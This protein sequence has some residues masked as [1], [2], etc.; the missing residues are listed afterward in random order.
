MHNSLI[1]NLNILLTF[2]TLIVSIVYCIKI[3]LSHTFKKWELLILSLSS[4]LVFI[5]SIDIFNFVPIALLIIPFFFYLFK[6]NIQYLV[7]KF[8][9]LVLYLIILAQSSKII[10]SLFLAAIKKI[11]YNYSIFLQNILFLSLLFLITKRINIILNSVVKNIIP[12]EKYKYILYFCALCTLTTYYIFLMYSIFKGSSYI[13]LLSVIT[14]LIFI[15]L[16]TYITVSVL[17]NIKLETNNKIESAKLEQQ[18]KYI[19][20]LEKNNNE[21]KKFKHDF[22]NIILGLDGYINNDDFDKEKL[23]K[24]FNSTIMNYNNNIEL[25]DI[26]IAKLNSIKVSSL[27]SLITNKVL[28]AQNNNIDVDINIQG[29]IHDFYTDEMQL[30]RILG[31]LLDNAIEASLELTHDKKIEMNIIQIDKTTDIQ[32]SNTFNNTGTPITDFNKE[33]FSTKGTN[34]GLGLSSAH[35]IANKLNILLNTEIDGNTFIQNLSIEGKY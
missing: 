11:E 34:R 25:N 28:V 16:C 20:A 8:T 17:K 6:K 9:F 12:S 1:Y 31:I 30:S 35:E 2:V 27:K 33:G 23:K 18:K 14:G 15:L 22:N 24:Y 13:R 10:L 32:I 4:S 5:I 19:L 3:F 26:V 21:I 7:I 29:E